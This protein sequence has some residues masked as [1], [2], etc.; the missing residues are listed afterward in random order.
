[1]SEKSEKVPPIRLGISTCLLG[2]KVRY[3]GGHKHDHFLT[4]VLGQYFEWV[5]VCPEV[6]IGLGTPRDTIRL[7]QQGNEVRFI[8]P[9]S[10][11]DHTEGMHQYAKRRVKELEKKNLCGFV[12]KRASPSCGMTRVRVYKESGMG[13]RK[14]ERSEV[15]GKLHKPCFSIPSMA[16]N[17]TRRH[18]TQRTY[19]VSPTA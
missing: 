5:P 4:D 19:S 8:M 10:G 17:G 16:T 13:I 15:S 14:A 2:D 6:E 7:V 11:R 18:D 3:D 9:K 1:M 12:L